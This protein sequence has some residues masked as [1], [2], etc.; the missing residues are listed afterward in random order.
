MIPKS[1][2]QATKAPTASDDVPDELAQGPNIRVW[3]DPELLIRI[4]GMG[5]THPGR[6]ELMG[7]VMLSARQNWARAIVRW[8]DDVGLSPFEARRMIPG[9][10]P[11]W[12]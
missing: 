3:A 8:A 1:P 7:D 2:K 9:R 4:D 12:P 11:Y 10:M 5:S 6:A